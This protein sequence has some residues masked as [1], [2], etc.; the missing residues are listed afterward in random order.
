M[1]R[2]LAW[3]LLRKVVRVWALLR[4]SIVDPQRESLGVCGEATERR[5][6]QAGKQY[7]ARGHS[8]RECAAVMP[9]YCCFDKTRRIKISQRKHLH[10]LRDAYTHTFPISSTRCVSHSLHAQAAK[11]GHTTLL[12]IRNWLRLR[13]F[14]VNSL[15]QHKWK[16]EL[17]KHASALWPFQHDLVSFKN[18]SV[19]CRWNAKWIQMRWRSSSVYHHRLGILV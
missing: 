6:R 8:S 9:F 3:Q 14:I 5:L 16:N 13:D 4:Y 7:L 2:E 15:N 11:S 1:A 12:Y 10:A 19:C 18:L 17:C